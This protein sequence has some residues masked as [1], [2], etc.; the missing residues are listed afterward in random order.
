MKRNVSQFVYSGSNVCFESHFLTEKNIISQM[1][2]VSAFGFS[3]SPLINRLIN[4]ALLVADHVSI[5]CYCCSNRCY[6]TSV[7]LL[8]T[9]A[10]QHTT[11]CA[12]KSTEL[13]Q[14]K[15]LNFTPDTW[16]PNRPDLN[17]V[18]YRIWTAIQECVYQKH[19]GMSNIIDELWLL[20]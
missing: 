6:Q 14:H 3:I 7:K 12:R 11:S 16:P 10:F 5:R 15:T 9:F 18:D 1:F 4:E 20:T 13:L 8:A 19:Q 17:P 2:K